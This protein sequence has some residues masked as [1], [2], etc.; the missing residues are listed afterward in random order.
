M[1]PVIQLLLNYPLEWYILPDI[2]LRLNQS[3]GRHILI[4]Y[5]LLQNLYLVFVDQHFSQ[6]L[7]RLNLDYL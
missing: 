2:Q 4:H 7:L 1:L 5:Q 3:L 6:L